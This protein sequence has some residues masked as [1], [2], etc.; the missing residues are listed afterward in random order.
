VEFDVSPWYGTRSIQLE[1]ED[2]TIRHSGG[3]VPRLVAVEGHVDA[4]GR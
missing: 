2:L 3:A 4:D 1:I